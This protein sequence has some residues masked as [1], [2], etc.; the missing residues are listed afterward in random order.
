[1]RKKKNGSKMK[2][3]N[4]IF[5]EMPPK[6]KRAA[7]DE[8]SEGRLDLVGRFIQRKSTNPKDFNCEKV[9]MKF[10]GNVVS[11]FIDQKWHIKT[12][13]VYPVFNVKQQILNQKCHASTG[14]KKDSKYNSVPPMF[15]TW[16]CM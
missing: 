11:H 10:T 14:R 7:A 2:L 4:E 8:I 5:E 12:D 3:R 13:P 6:Q 16:I 15:Q 1:M 9:V